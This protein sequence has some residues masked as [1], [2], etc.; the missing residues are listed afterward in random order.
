[1]LG[2]FVTGLGNGAGTMVGPNMRYIGHH[3]MRFIFPPVTSQYIY[4]SSKVINCYLA[5]IAP[6]TL[7]GALG[8][9]NQLAIVVSR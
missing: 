2:R 8:A 6:G 5:E 4:F 9:M 7:R 3:F 1:M